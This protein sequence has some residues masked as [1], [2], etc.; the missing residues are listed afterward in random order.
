MVSRT[1]CGT[2][3]TTAPVPSSPRPCSCWLTTTS[4][5]SV[6]NSSSKVPLRVSVKMNVPTTNATPEDHGQA[7]EQHAALVRHE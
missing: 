3:D 5:A 2:T 1:D 6:L 4:G 7:G